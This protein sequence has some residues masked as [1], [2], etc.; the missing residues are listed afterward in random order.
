MTR[1]QRFWAMVKK[2]SPNACWLWLGCIK[3]QG[4]GDFC[5]RYPSRHCSA[6][7]FSY[8]LHFG[9]I[10]KGKWV[11]HSCDNR[12]C[13]NPAHLF[14]GTNLDNVRDMVSKRRHR[15]RGLT[16]NNPHV[17]ITRRQLGNGTIKFEAVIWNGKSQKYLGRFADLK[18]AIR[19]RYLSSIHV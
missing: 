10:P 15:P 18:E 2:G 13:V 8:T 16:P 12:A 4:Y 7:R 3:P 6:H 1:A 19:A 9:K 11:L 5:Y 14:L 17:G